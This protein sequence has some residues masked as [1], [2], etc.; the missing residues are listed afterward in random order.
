MEMKAAA[1]QMAV[2]DRLDAHDYGI[3]HWNRLVFRYVPA[4][5]LGRSFKEAMY[6]RINGENTRILA[7]DLN[8]QTYEHFGYRKGMGLTT[9]GITDAYGSFWYFGFVKFVVIAAIMKR[10]YLSA[11]RGSFTHQVFYLILIVPAMHI[12]S[13]NTN[14]FFGIMP[15]MVAFLLPALL[16]ARSRPSEK[17]KQASSSANSRVRA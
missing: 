14:W 15:H 12:V 5:L 4:Q 3:Y 2:I 8:D 7:T 13:H 1:Y 11:R 9:G 10:L 17:P 16:Y 6:L